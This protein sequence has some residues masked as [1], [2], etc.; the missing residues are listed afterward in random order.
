[1]EYEIVEKQPFHVFGV[2]RT[3]PHAGG[4]WETVKQDGSLRRM[5]ETAGA[6]FVSLGLC[7]GFDSEG[8]NDYMCAFASD[9]EEIPGFERYDCP[10]SAWLV[11]EAKGSISGDALGNAWSRIHS[12]FLPQSGCRQRGLPTVEQYLLWDEK[13]DACAVRILVPVEK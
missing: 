9:A 11:C 5:Q 4:T 10:A 12:E 3:T 1:M 8:S 6:D 13:A 2:R 7:F